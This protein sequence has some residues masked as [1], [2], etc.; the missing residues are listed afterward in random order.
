MC[1]TYSLS[2]IHSTNILDLDRQ[3]TEKR[4]REAGGGWRELES[5]RPAYFSC[6]MWEQLL[7][8]WVSLPP[9]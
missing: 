8:L 3:D 4:G 9:L 6:L 7:F 2:F 5:N 1:R